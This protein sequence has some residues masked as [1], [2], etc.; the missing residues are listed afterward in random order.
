MRNAFLGAGSSIPPDLIY[1]AVLYAGYGA[2][3]NLVIDPSDSRCTDGSSQSVTNALGDGVTFYRGTDSSNELEDPSFVG[4]VGAFS[5]SP[6]FDF[7][8]ASDQQLLTRSVNATYSN[9]WHKNGGKFT[10][11]AVAVRAG[12]TLNERSLYRIAAADNNS[13][14][15]DGGMDF[16]K[17]NT[18]TVQLFY[19]TNNTSGSATFTSTA[20]LR[21]NAISCCGV[22]VNLT[23]GSLAGNFLIDTADESFTPTASTCTDTPAYKDTI[24]GSSKS[25]AAPFPNLRMYGIICW[26]DYLGAS[27]MRSVYNALKG[28]RFE[29]LP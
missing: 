9:G 24:W 1:D 27:G 16:L 26:S 4:T 28:S 2:S 5:P 13:S 23:T 22:S 19:K 3:L 15:T 20:T 21:Q 17:T 25:P 6:Y 29:S 11:M 8:D 14:V 7:T 18:N 10:I 12:T